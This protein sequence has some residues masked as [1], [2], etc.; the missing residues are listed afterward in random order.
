[1]HGGSGI[2]REYVLEAIKNGITKINIGTEIRQ[3]YERGLGENANIEE[4]QKETK[5]K[6]EELITSYYEIGGSVHILSEKL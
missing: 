4:A 2:K 1:L 3:A 5:E 6:V